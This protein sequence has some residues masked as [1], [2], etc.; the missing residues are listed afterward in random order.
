PGT[1][2]FGAIDP[3]ATIAAAARRDGLWF[4]VDAAYGGA[5]LLSTAHARR[6]AGIE[7]ADSIAVD[8]HKAFFQPIS[9]AA[10]LLADARRFDLIRVNADYLNSEERE[11][12][13]IPDLV[14]QSLLTT[15]RFDALKLWVS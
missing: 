3:L 13:G 10:F 11:A 15:R 4:H 1:T 7:Q 9:C 6:L 8:F 5:L 2:D 14:T 12:D